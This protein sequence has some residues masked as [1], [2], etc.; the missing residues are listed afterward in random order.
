MINKEWKVDVKVDEEIIEVVV[1]WIVN[2]G[3]GL[4]ELS[5]FKFD[6]EDVFLKFIYGN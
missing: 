3:L 4:F 1:V 5:L 6:L 2:K